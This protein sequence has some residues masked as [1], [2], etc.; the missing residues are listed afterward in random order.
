M[1]LY[2]LAI[3][4]IIILSIIIISCNHRLTGQ[5]QLQLAQAEEYFKKAEELFNTHKYQQS[6]EMYNRAAGLFESEKATERYLDC[7]TQ[8]SRNLLTLD[9]YDSTIWLMNRVIDIAREELGE[10]NSSIAVAYNRLAYAY[11]DLSDYH[12]ALDYDLKNYHLN[13]E[14]HGDTSVHT[15]RSCYNLAHSYNFLDRYDECIAYCEKALDALNE[16]SLKN[17][18]LLLGSFYY[19]LGMSYASQWDFD[20]A[21]NYGLKSLE[22]T[23]QTYGEISEQTAKAYSDIASIIYQKMGD[24]QNAFA[25]LREGLNIILQ[26]EVTPKDALSNA[27]INLGRLHNKQNQYDSALFYLQKADQMYQEFYPYHYHSVLLKI[28]IAHVYESQRLWDDA[29]QYLKMAESIYEDRTD[30]NPEYAANLYK[31]LGNHFNRRFD[32]ETALQY[33][34]RGLDSLDLGP[35]KGADIYAEV[36][37]ENYLSALEA[38]P[39]LQNKAWTLFDS[40]KEDRK[41]KKLRAAEAHFTV[42]VQGLDSI[43]T[44]L[45]ENGSKQYLLEYHYDLYAGLLEANLELYRLHNKKEYLEKAFWAAEQSRSKLLLENLVASNLTEF[46]GVPERVLSLEKN[47]LSDIAFYKEKLSNYDV[48]KNPGDYPEIDVWKERVFQL[49]RKKDSLLAVIKKKYPRYYQTKYDLSTRSITQIQQALPARACLVEYFMADSTLF[50]FI[51]D[52]REVHAVTCEL[53][54]SL[55]SMILD[56]RKNLSSAGISSPSDS[57]YKIYRQS[58]QLY[59]RIFAPVQSKLPAGTTKLIISPNGLL[60]L[61]PFEVLVSTEPKL[62]GGFRQIDYLL[63]DYE[64]SYTPSA[65]I[66]HN[67]PRDRKNDWSVQFAGYANSYADAA[68]AINSEFRAGSL[69]TQLTPLK[70]AKIEVQKAF[71][72]FSGSL[73]IDEN[74]SE[75]AFRKHGTRSRIVHLALHALVDDKN[76]MHSRLIFADNESDTLDDGFLNAYELYN[77]DINADM[78]VLS[79]C[80]TG[81]G[82][83]EKGE[84]VMSLSRAFSY[85]GSKSLVMSLWSAN[86][87]TTTTLMEYFYQAL[88]QGKT[89]DAA[90]REAKLKYLQSA[91]PLLAHPYYWGAFIVSGDLQ[92]LKS[93]R[94]STIIFWS[95]LVFL[96]LIAAFFILRKEVLK[97][98]QNIETIR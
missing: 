91:D 58:H 62:N 59:Q 61:L 63:Y 95:G 84:G 10:V 90:L 22:L 2:R 81:F 72:Y 47:L 31:H 49:K 16:S 21:L 11:T 9:Y 94:L 48:I 27:Y 37:L 46:N 85:A 24:Y 54:D 36:A 35:S 96:L 86:D 57:L 45:R 97:K 12:R 4:E 13:L 67:K 79:A 17:E 14:M 29:L 8:S 44:N 82:Q 88:K 98:R 34:Q 87:Q 52:R 71:Q 93:D 41:E 66:W 55:D 25:F 50:S 51:I 32:F 65:T 33:Y 70:Y 56:F 23:K 78:V 3:K 40:Y 7:L 73:F 5:S 19:L 53:H 64:V 6:A 68:L 80:N 89:K 75:S 15:I 1:I 39:L 30:K 38:V 18:K 77:M 69:R 76:P 43:R 74:A 60:S 83:V 92:P 28:D 26:L 20:R 42:A